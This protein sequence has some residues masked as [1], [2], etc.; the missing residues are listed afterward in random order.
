[1]ITQSLNNTTLFNIPDK[2]MTV[3]LT[4]YNQLLFFSFLINIISNYSVLHQL[5]GINL[6]VLLTLIGLSKY[7]YVSPLP[8]DVMHLDLIGVVAV[9][10]T[11]TQI[12]QLRTEQK[13]I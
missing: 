1:M 2:N 3:V 7:F 4:T 10:P 5:D 8:F 9:V 11:Q 13:R 12:I 6:I